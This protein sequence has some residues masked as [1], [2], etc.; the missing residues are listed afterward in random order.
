MSLV[1][2]AVRKAITESIKIQKETRDLLKQ[3]LIDQK[4]ADSRLAN[5]MQTVLFAETAAAR[6]KNAT[7]N[8]SYRRTQTT[9]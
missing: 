6:V 5:A 1:D 9:P 8:E 2:D 7:A 3:G 4:E